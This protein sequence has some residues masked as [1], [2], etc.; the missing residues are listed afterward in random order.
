[1]P[2]PVRKIKSKLNTQ[3]GNESPGQTAVRSV[4]T[5]LASYRL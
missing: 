3:T 1:M 4:L 2:E 5:K